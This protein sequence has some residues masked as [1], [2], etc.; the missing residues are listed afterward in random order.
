MVTKYVRDVS[1]QPKPE[2]GLRELVYS[3][4]TSTI[5]GFNPAEAREGFKREKIDLLNSTLALWN[6]F[7]YH[8]TFAYVLG[9]M[10]E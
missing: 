10:Q 9:L 4:S 6:F 8:H 2:K 3:H 1:I 7:E 5:T